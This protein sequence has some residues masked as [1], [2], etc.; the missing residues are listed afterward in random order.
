MSKNISKVNIKVGSPTK[1][2]FEVSVRDK[3]KFRVNKEVP[4]LIGT[5]VSIKENEDGPSFF[6]DLGDDKGKPVNYDQFVSFFIEDNKDNKKANNN[7]TYEVSLSQCD[8]I[9]NVTTKKIFG[10]GADFITKEI[11]LN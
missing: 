1:D 5:V 2:T 6:V 10:V 3:I 4:S 11:N 8:V 7:R 9:Y